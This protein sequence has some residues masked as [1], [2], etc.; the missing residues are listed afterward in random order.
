MFREINPEDICHYQP[1]PKEA[2][3]VSFKQKENGPESPGP[4]ELTERG[5]EGVVSDAYI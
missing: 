2:I 3:T 1:S 5:R 4:Q